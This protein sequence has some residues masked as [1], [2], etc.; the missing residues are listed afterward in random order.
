MDIEPVT[1]KAMNVKFRVQINSLIKKEIINTKRLR[2]LN[3]TFYE[4]AKPYT[5]HFPLFWT[6]EGGELTKERARFLQDEVN[7]SS[8]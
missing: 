8:S 6:E 2:P 4:T 1:G 7:L 5:K 3:M